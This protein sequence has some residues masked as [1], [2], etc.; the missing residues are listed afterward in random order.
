MSR[1]ER[2]KVAIYRN[3]RMAALH[4]FFHLIPLGGAIALLVLRWKQYWIGYEA[5]DI[6]RLQFVAKLHE[7][8]MQFC[9]TARC[10][11]CRHEILRRVCMSLYC[12]SII[13]QLMSKPLRGM[14]SDT[15]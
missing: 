2:W 8:L 13:A 3:R 9:R 11:G 1:I 10:V 12:S 6:T 4:T 15:V 5:T 14:I 7:L